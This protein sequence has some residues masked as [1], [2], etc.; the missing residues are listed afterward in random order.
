MFLLNSRSALVTATSRSRGWHPLSRSY[1]AN[2]P[3]SL[4]FRCADTPWAFHPGAPVSHLGTVTELAPSSFSRA[5]GLGPTAVT[6]G[7]SR[8]HQVLTITVL[9][10]LRRLDTRIR[11]K[12]LARCIGRRTEALWLQNINWI[13]IRSSRLRYSLGPAN[14]RLTIIAEEP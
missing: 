11:V 5:P 10:R 6:R 7:R 2:L 9:P 12:D 1:G 14:P 13:P 8:F 3:S 4:A